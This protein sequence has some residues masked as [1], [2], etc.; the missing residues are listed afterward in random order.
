M[1]NDHDPLIT[2]DWLAERLDDPG[3]RI[4]DIRGYVKKTDLGG[5]RQRAEYLGA[6]DEYDEAHLPGA[7]YVDWT[8]DI[9]DPDAPV[10]AQ[11]FGHRRRNECRRLRPRR[12]PVRDPPLVGSHLLRP[13]R[14]LRPRR[15]LEEM[16]RR[17][18]PDDRRGPGPRA[19][20]LHPEAATR[21]AERG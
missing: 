18:S 21:V 5:D 20:H 7:V 17:G 10:P 16:G 11:L 9:T 4:V 8:R 6:R 3:M 12:R 13:R 14:G 1:P 19:R 2:T 15:R